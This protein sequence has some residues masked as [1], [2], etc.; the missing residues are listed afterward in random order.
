VYCTYILISSPRIGGT[1]PREG[2]S[3]GAVAPVV[4]HRCWSTW[5][6]SFSVRIT[7]ILEILGCCP[8]ILV[9]YGLRG[10]FR[11]WTALQTRNKFAISTWK[12]NCGCGDVNCWLKPNPHP[13]THTRECISWLLPVHAWEVETLLCSAN[14]TSVW[15]A[16]IKSHHMDLK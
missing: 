16:V 4:G 9:H 1:P 5:N 7:H 10:L 14:L 6:W 15:W 2:T 3:Q 12:I 8:E 11:E 13:A